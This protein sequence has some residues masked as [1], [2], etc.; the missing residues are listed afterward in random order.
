MGDP[1]DRLSHLHPRF[2]LVNVRFR[3][4]HAEATEIEDPSEAPTIDLHVNL[5][6]MDDLGDADFREVRVAIAFT[7]ELPEGRLVVVPEATYVVPREVAHEIDMPL[8]VEFVNHVAVM[9]LIPYAR[10][11]LSDL[12]SR[13]LEARIT[14]PVFPRG[15][16]HFAIPEEHSAGKA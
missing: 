10:E 12:S 6:E 8:V 5:Q 11:A 1:S 3:Q 15:A 4:L 13:V 7:L 2:N 9:V 14:M 16:I